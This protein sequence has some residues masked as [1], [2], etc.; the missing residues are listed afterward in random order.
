MPMPTKYRPEMC[1][2]A[3]KLCLLGATD[4]QLADFFEV[5]EVN[6]R[7]WKT[8]H[9]EFGEAL[10]KA[11]DEADGTIAQALFHR[12][13]GYKHLAVKFFQ[14]EGKIIHKRYVEHLA[15]DTTACIFWLKN[16]RPDVWR[17]RHELTGANGGAIEHKIEDVTDVEAARAVAFAMAE[18]AH[19]VT[20]A[21][22]SGNAAAKEKV[23]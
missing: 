3:R 21:K 15:P 12:A 2:Q 9:P 6:L 19:A 4:K 8:K 13:R 18:G 14:H 5:H 1:V 22:R 7:E 11:K 16:R 10:R 17:D 20:K 23:T